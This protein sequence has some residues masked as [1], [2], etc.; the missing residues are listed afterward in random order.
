VRSFATTFANTEV[1]ALTGISKSTLSRV[2]SDQLSL[3]YDKLL[4]LLIPPTPSRALP[5]RKQ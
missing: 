1:S 5:A 3:T 2:E 4:Q